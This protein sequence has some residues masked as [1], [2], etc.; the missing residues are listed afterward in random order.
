MAWSCHYATECFVAYFFIEIRLKYEKNILLSSSRAF[1]LSTPMENSKQCCLSA[2]ELFHCL[3][4][5]FWCLPGPVENSEATWKK[6]TKCDK[7]F[8]FGWFIDDK[9]GNH[10]SEKRCLFPYS[11]FIFVNNLLECSALT[12]PVF[13][14][15]NKTHWE[16]SGDSLLH[17]YESPKI[18]WN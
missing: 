12:F 18:S 5:L 9:I 13:F 7:Y 17:N 3:P 10:S 11:I 4:P 2:L 8:V 6:A 14:Q 15:D 16:T 1:S